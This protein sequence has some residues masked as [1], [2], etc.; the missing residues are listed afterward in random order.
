MAIMLKAVFCLSLLIYRI[1]TAVTDIVDHYISGFH[2]KQ[3]WVQ[4]IL[5]NALSVQWMQNLHIQIWL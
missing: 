4:I 1:Q 2:N 3:N 5:N